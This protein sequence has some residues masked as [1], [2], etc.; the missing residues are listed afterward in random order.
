MFSEMLEE[1][2]ATL[3][4]ELKQE[5][6]SQVQEPPPPPPPP[7]KYLSVEQF[8]GL[9]Q[10]VDGMNETINKIYS[11]LDNIPDGHARRSESTGYDGDGGHQFI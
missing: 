1:M 3:K 10:K 7:V 11:A 4:T 5:F 6:A 9:A 8:N 2:K